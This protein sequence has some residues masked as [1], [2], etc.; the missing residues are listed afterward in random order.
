MAATV[1]NSAKGIGDY[2]QTIDQNIKDLNDQLSRSNDSVKTVWLSWQDQNFRDFKKNFDID[3]E[4]I[5]E[6]VRILTEYKDTILDQLRIK[7]AEYENFSM[8]RI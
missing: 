3:K 2:Q 8:S 1:I 6:L 7:L 4:Q 5:N